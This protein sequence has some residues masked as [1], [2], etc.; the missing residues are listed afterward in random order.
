MAKNLMPPWMR[1]VA[2]FNPLNWSLDAG[3]AALADNPDWTTVVINGG[4]LLAL[5]VLMVWLST[6]T[7]RAYQKSV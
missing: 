7:F 4:W 6:R 2:A 3:R 1:D 5:A